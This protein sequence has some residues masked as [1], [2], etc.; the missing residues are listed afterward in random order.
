M[1]HRVVWRHRRACR[2]YMLAHEAGCLTMLGNAWAA[3]YVMDPTR[4]RAGRYYIHTPEPEG[5]VDGV[6][7]VFN[8]GN[9]MVHTASPQAI[10]AFAPVLAQ[11]RFHTVWAFGMK[12]YEAE[13]ILRDLP[14]VRCTCQPHFL[15]E[16]REVAASAAENVLTY[17][18]IRTEP[19]HR[20]VVSFTQRIL[21][22]CFGHRTSPEIIAKRT[23]ERKPQEIY[24]VGLAGRKMVCQCHI[25]AWGERYAHI[26]G[27]AT[28]PEERGKGYASMIMEEMCAYIRESGRIPS[29]TVHCDN[30]GAQALYRKL[31]FDVAQTVWVLECDD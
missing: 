14:D 31:G 20:D 5:A 11:W 4:L 2:N 17:R 19:F 6:L 7:A 26:G 27:V 8:D 13:D 3:G 22:E 12:R 25:Q 16:Q 29:L 15:M 10:E 9:A 23:R 21:W 24:L 1:V 30:M 18:D 28:L